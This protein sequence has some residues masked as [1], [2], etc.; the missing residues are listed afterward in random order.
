M[1]RIR[2]RKQGEG[3][4]FVTCR[5]CGK[6]LLWVTPSHLMGPHGWTTPHPQEEYKRRFGV[7]R[8]DCLRTARKR[9]RHSALALALRGRLWSRERLRGL[10][11]DRLRRG[12]PVNLGAVERECPTA[13]REA[14]RFF[15]G[16]TGLLEDCGLKVE[17]ILL[18]RRWT[19]SAVLAAVRAA[20]RRGEELSDAAARSRDPGLHA[21]AISRF[22]SWDGALRAAGL[23]PSRFRRYRR[24]SREGVI[25]A[26]RRIRGP[27]GQRAVRVADPSLIVAGRRFFGTWVRAVRAAGRPYPAPR[28][29]W[30][31]EALAA[32]GK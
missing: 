20:G 16:W 10:V 19:P 30:G 27:L 24:W 26:I 25:D 28:R 32:G 14:V 5:L 11:R 6:A 23:D 7:A 31:R 22:G 9:E 18:R 12:L 2:R 3:V 4:D 17:E 1:P 8:T 29:P 15:G 13:P 21:A